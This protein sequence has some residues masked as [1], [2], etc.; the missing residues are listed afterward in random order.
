ML[1]LERLLTIIYILLLNLCYVTSTFQDFLNLL[2]I[3]EGDRIGK[4]ADDPTFVILFVLF[5]NVFIP[6]LS[7][8]YIL[9]NRTQDYLNLNV[10][11]LWKCP[12]EVW[13]M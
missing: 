11:L 5:Q 4:C 3:V 2:K 9:L 8:E 12:K 13:H 10:T 1:K 7:L 6:F